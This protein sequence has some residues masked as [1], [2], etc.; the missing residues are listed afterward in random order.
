MR[1]VLV[2]FWWERGTLRNCNARRVR[3]IFGSTKTPLATVLFV[4]AYFFDSEEF[5]NNRCAL[6]E[7]R[8]QGTSTSA[9]E[10]VDW[11]RRLAA[12]ASARGRATLQKNIPQIYVGPDRHRMGAGVWHCAPC[13]PPST[14]H[15][16]ELVV[17]LAAGGKR[18]EFCS[19]ARPCHR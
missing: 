2:G 5:K 11:S 4:I 10:F 12:R 18:P 14:T 15:L 9:I 8:S 3:R 13:P 16:P 7:L 6:R 19:P 17:I 1:S